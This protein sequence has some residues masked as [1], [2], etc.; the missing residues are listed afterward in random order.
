MADAAVNIKKLSLELGGKSPNII[1]DDANFEAAVRGAVRGQML[2]TA[3]Q[4]CF[5]GT[6]L[7]IQNSIY[8][9]FKEKIIKVM[10]E[11]KI[12]DSLDSTTEVGPLISESQ[13]EVVMRHI[14]EGKETASLL[15]GGK[16]LNDSG[17]S[18]GV[19]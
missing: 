18:K 12:G 6:R 1:F 17:H 3:G 8:E 2:G 19:S 7:L 5:A 13:A 9:R 15:L 14:N 11:L 10:P 4:V 16:R